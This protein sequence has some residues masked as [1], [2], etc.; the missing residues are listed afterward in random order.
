MFELLLKLQR[1]VTR[2]LTHCRLSVTR[3]VRGGVC[4]ATRAGEIKPPTDFLHPA[5]ELT[6]LLPYVTVEPCGAVGPVPHL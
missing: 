5:S 6:D 2:V 1:P 4:R 3:H